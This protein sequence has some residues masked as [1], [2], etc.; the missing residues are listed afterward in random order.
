MVVKQHQLNNCEPFLAILDHDRR[1]MDHPEVT[2]VET[3]D[4]N[5]MYL[6]MYPVTPRVC[7]G[8]N[9]S[10]SSPLVYSVSLFQTQALVLQTSP[11]YKK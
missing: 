7:V 5:S 1:I 8:E 6:Q 2:D 4:C 10:T 11:L 9:F 3:P